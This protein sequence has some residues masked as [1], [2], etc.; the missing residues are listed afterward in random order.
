MHEPAI[1]D[2]TDDEL[3]ARGGL[4]WSYPQP[5]VLPAWVAETDVAPDPVVQR[6]VADAVAK[7]DLGYPQFDADS[8][9]PE[10]LADYAGRQWGWTIEPDRV[11]VTADVMHGIYLALTTL[12][13]DAPVVVPTP[14]YPPFLQVVPHAGRS[15]VTVPLDPDA[16]RAELDLQRIDEAMAGGARTVLLCN[17]HNPWGRAFRREELAGLLEVV[18]R[19][20]GRIVSDEIHAGLVLPGSEH[21]PLATLPGGAEVT[22]TVL[23]ASKAWNLP[24]LKCAQVVSGTAADAKVMRGLPMI[25]N[26][27]TSSLGVVAAQAAYTGG[28]PWLDAWV[29]RLADNRRLFAEL[30]A[31]RLPQARLRQLEATYLAWLDVRA[32]GHHDPAAVALQRGRVMVNN[33]RSFG[34]GGEG[35][36][37]VNLAT[38]PERVVRIVD[39]LAAG[40][41]RT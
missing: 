11:T 26:H 41:A 23:S 6:A 31:D 40:L 37:R 17:P 10:V 15:M 4:K 3:R 19:H 7:G 27:G 34:P 12:C 25:A 22:T 2:L 14:T 9:L 36:V 5:D 35:H 38:S 8:G 24:A 28:Q 13:E 32:Y 18:H 33:G 39:R 1:V 21:V 20:G 30:V 16:E 29:A